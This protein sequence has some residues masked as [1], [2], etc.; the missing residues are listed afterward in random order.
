[1]AKVKI[2]QVKSGIKTPKTQKLT[3]QALGLGRMNKTVEKEMN[4]SLQGMINV[5]SHL[6]TVTEA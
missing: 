2:T 4:P 1:M 3:L 5:V 6:V